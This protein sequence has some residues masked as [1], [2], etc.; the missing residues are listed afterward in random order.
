MSTE[1][2]YWWRVT[3][4]IW[5]VLLL[6]LRKFPS[7]QD[8]SGHYPDLVSD[9]SSVWNFFARS[10][11]DVISRGNQWWR[12]QISAVS[13]ASFPGFSLASTEEEKEPWEGGCSFFSYCR[14]WLLLTHSTHLLRD[15]AHN[16]TE[17]APRP[18]PAQY[19]RRLLLCR[20]CNLHQPM[21]L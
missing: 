6:W 15:S 18:D 2:S 12:C 11:S 5:V 16:P 13:S 20:L 3:T 21:S 7:R 14:F 17:P 19:H 9:T 1:I 4:Q 10:S 8:Q